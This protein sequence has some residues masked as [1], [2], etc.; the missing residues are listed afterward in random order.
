MKDNNT[1]IKCGCKFDFA[2]FILIVGY[3]M[4]GMVPAAPFCSAR[5]FDDFVAKYIKFRSKSDEKSNSTNMKG[6]E[7]NESQ[8]IEK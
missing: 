1:C 8:N 5:C 6:G 7:K 2:A 3:K 4:E